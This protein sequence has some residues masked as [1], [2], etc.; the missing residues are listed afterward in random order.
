MKKTILTAAMLIA[1][2]SF[3]QKKEI[4][5]A[6]KAIGSNDIAGANAQISA[7]EAEM[8]DKTYLLEPAVLEQYYYTKGLIAIKNGKISEGAPYLAKI[9]DLGKTNIYTGKDASKNKVY[10]VGKAAADASG[11]SGLKAEKYTPST[12]NKLAEELNPLIQKSNKEAVDLYNA[13][14]YA[15][16]APKFEEVYNLL[17][18]A[19]QNNQQYLY[20]AGIN[21]AL[22]NKKDQAAAIYT[23]LINSGYT[24]VE[25]IYS[26]KNEKTGKQENMDKSQWEIMKK[27]G[28]G[29]GFSDF[30]SEVSP[31][32]E[33]ELYET[34]AALL[35]DNNKFDEALNIIDKGLKKFPNNAKL[36]ELQ[37]ITY[38]KSGKTD[39]FVKSLKA[40]LAKNPNDKINWFNLGVLLGKDDATKT[41][42]LAAYDKVIQ[43]DPAY[44]NA[45]I[46]AAYLLMGDD[47]KTIDSFNALKKAGKMD[48][49][50][51]VLEERRGRFAKAIPYAE[52]WHA[53]QPD[54]IGAVSLLKD[55]YLVTKNETKAAEYKAKETAMKK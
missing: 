9:A 10:Y 6:Y 26:A 43:L 46:N 12:T 8:Q 29:S 55:L 39:E 3:A 23:D 28:S 53:L 22:A 35:I 1:V 47:S 16:A 15:A 42:A 32:V 52:K 27:A 18:A 48:D 24:G 19:G 34:A 2:F 31:S 14:N 45:Y 36:S 38:H 49:A 20:Y 4:S 25:T 5:A 50:N 13:K 11:I 51:K 44:T 40:Q 37:G 17:K 21:Y 7:A 33:S 41:E 30:K 54:E